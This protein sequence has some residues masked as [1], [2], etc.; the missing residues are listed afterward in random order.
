MNPGFGEKV[1]IRVKFLYRFFM[2]S[3]VPG[4]NDGLSNEDLK[5]FPG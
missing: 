5:G 2:P 3:P 4:P 1:G